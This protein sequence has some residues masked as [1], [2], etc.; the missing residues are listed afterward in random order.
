[1]SADIDGSPNFDAHPAP[2]SLVSPV[3]ALKTQQEVPDSDNDESLEQLAERQ[4][5]DYW[6]MLGVEDEPIALYPSSPRPAVSTG[7]YLIF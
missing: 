2:Y 6:S 7:S 3:H 4:E 5:Q 1:M